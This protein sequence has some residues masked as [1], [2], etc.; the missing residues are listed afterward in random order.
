METSFFLGR[1]DDVMIFSGVNIYPREIEN[2]LEMHPAVSEAAAFPFLWEGEQI[3]FAAVCL[4][5]P[6]SE[7]ELKQFCISQMGWRTPQRIIGVDS[8]PRNGAGKVLKKELA[9]TV[10]KML[11]TP[12]KDEFLTMMSPPHNYPTKKHL[13]NSLF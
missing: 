10:H 11:Q 9:K 13:Y 5:I 7:E 12:K 4:N 1:S 2:V 8:F 3:P 6:V